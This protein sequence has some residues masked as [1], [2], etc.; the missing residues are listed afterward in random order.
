MRILSSRDP[1]VERILQK[2]IANAAEIESRVREIVEE[3]R[4]RGDAAVL[5]YTRRFDR[6]PAEWDNLRV[7]AE[8]IEQARALVDGEFLDSLQAAIDNIRSFHEQQKQHSWMEPDPSGNILGQISRPLERVGIYVPGGTAAYPSSVLMN[9]LPAQVAGVKEI[10]M[11]SPPAA[12]GSLNPYTLVAAAAC[13]VTE[14]YKIGGAQAVAALAFGTQTVPKV[15]KITGPGN[16]YVTMAKKLVYGEVDID[17]LA[18]PSEVLVVAD[19][20]AN[21]RYAAADLLSQ[22][23]HDPLASALLVTP[24][25]ELAQAVKLEVERQLAGLSRRAIAEKALAE[26]GAIII[27]EDLAEAIEVANR[28]APEH[29]ELLVAEPFSWLGKVKNA[30]AVFV[31][32]YSP[33]PIGDYFAG[34]NHI[35]PTGGTARFYSPVTVDTFTK[36]T[37]VIAYSEAGFRV[38]AAKV[39]KLA[40]V[41]GLDAHANSIK[42]RLEP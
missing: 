37:S 21:P 10:I 4:Q 35:L 36:K 29:L 17:M 23:E 28:F 39:I 31:G 12:D 18:G 38:A 5:E 42:I 24:S 7:S 22:A 19:A 30:G 3:V 13:G 6:V 27:T 9:A 41:E 32:H 15:D 14:I 34:P 2:T 26:Y 33:E 1:A 8:E 11:V 20:T 25:T 40:T 16:I